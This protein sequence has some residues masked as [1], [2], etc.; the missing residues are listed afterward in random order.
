MVLS[1]KTGESA[2]PEESSSFSGSLFHHSDS[3]HCCG[4]KR[5]SDMHFGKKILMTLVG[6]LLVYVIIFVGTLMRNNIKKYDTIGVADQTDRTISIDGFGKVTGAN[7]IAMTTIG[8]SNTDKDVSKA[9][10]DNKRVM[11]QVMADLKKMGVADKD[12]RSDYSI[13]P[14]YN[15]TEKGGKE[16]R[17]YRV[18]NNVTVKIRDL[19]KIADVLTLVSKYGATEV[20]GLSF[21]IDDPENLKM[22]ARDKALVDAQ[23]KARK[24]SRALGIELEALVAYSEYEVGAVDYSGSNFRGA[25]MSASADSMAPAVPEIASGSKEVSMNVNLIYKIRQ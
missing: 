18:T 16:F 10:A 23:L 9:Q 4:P 14:D 13:Y 2:S 3:Q 20:N 24:L 1:K 22:K 11:D 19:S 12:L 25:S 21:T 5:M 8:F 7:D 6:V 15:Y 17:G